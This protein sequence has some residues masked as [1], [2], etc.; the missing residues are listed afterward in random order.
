MK[1]ETVRSDNVVQKEQS[2]TS[3]AYSCIVAS[4]ANLH[5]GVLLD[6]DLDMIAADALLIRLDNPSES[7]QASRTHD[8]TKKR[9]VRRSCFKDIL[10]STSN[11]IQHI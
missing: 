7:S 11:F 8:H 9:V 6:R 5:Y 3:W 10:Q 2:A 4:T 1:G